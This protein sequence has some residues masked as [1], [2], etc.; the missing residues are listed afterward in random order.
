MF[1]HL[2]VLHLGLNMLC[3]YRASIVEAI[4]GHARML[5]IYVI[6]GLGGGAATVMF[7][8]PNVVTVGA[9]GAVFGIYGAFGVF[10]LLRRSL[11][12]PEVW[13]PLARSLGSF[14]VLNLV[15]GLAAQGI[16]LTAHIGGLVVGSALAAILLLA[17]RRSVPAQ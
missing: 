1:L 11:I 8:P 17:K 4:Y 16:S 5:A 9:S 7:G 14:L 3:L 10:L 15:I 13:Q 12:P 2:G 6:A